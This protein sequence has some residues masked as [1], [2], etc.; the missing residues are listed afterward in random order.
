MRPNWS[1]PQKAHRFSR[2]MSND[3]IGLVRRI[4]WLLDLDEN[5]AE[6]V[7]YARDIAMEIKNGTSQQKS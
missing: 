5:D 2:S 1:N 7:I 4:I 3:D 6:D